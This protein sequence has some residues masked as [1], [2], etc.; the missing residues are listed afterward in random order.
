MAAELQ[1][2]AQRKRFYCSYWDWHNKPVKELGILS[3]FLK[4]LK[5]LGMESVFTSLRQRSQGED[6]PDFEGQDNAGR[7]IG[8]ELTELVDEKTVN[9]RQVD[10][11][12]EYKSYTPSEAIERIEQIIREKDVKCYRG[13]P[14]QRIVLLIFTDEYFLEPL[15]V[16]DAIRRHLFRRGVNVQEAFLFYSP[17][18]ATSD[19]PCI[20][21]KLVIP[22]SDIA[23][24]GS[25][26]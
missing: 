6:P 14:Y 1:K 11:R 19:D 8:I 22:T 4:V 3:D 5:A 12:L 23:K 13:G 17:R 25:A 26:K 21:L 15:D 20:P 24:S 18:P 16:R 9:K 7:T 10:R 2:A